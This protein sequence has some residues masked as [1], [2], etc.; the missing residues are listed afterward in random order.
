MIVVCIRAGLGLL[1]DSNKRFLLPFRK[2]KDS[3]QTQKCILLLRVKNHHHHNRK[4][5]YLDDV[6][7]ELKKKK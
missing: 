3:L 7:C 2:I 4:T 5:M 6:E 1:A